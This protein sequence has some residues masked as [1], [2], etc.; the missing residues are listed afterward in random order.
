MRRTVVRHGVGLLSILLA[1]VPLLAGSRQ[2]A[3]SA[4]PAQEVK[5]SLPPARDVLERHIKAVGGRDAAMRHS[6][7]H[8]MG[9]MA[10]ASTGLSGTFETFEAKP[11]K[12]LMRMTIAGVGEISEGYNGQV[13]WSINPVSGPSLL[14]GKQL[15]ERKRDS[16]FFGDLEPARRYASM[17][18][19]E[20]VT[21]DGR[22]CFKVR[23][24]RHE[25]GEDIHFY[26]V[27]SGLRAGT[28]MTRESPMG[29]IAATTTETGY[30]KFGSVL[31]PTKIVNSAMGLEQVM[32][33][34]TVSFDTV[35]PSVFD[36]PALI[37]ALI[38]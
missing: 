33:I 34:S 32:Q 25:G 14:E 21:F 6:S 18:T 23:L 10:M 31:F 9:T 11:N 5:D 30:K 35:D 36:P 19:L 3:G 2:T 38:K 28:S 26:D 22:P 4:V 7:R 1:A 13:G 15:E 17:A 27:A 37:K 12:S 8:V 20:R 29:P 24:V 16:E